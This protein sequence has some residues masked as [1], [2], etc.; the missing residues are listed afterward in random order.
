[1]AAAPGDSPRSYDLYLAEGPRR[2]FVKLTVHGITV[3]DRGLAW[4]SGGTACEAPFTD[5]AAIHLGAG[6]IGQSTLD[7]CRIEFT[8]GDG[9]AA[10]DWSASG[11]PDDGKLPIYRDF[12][13]DLHARLA[14]RSFGAI[15]F[16][17]GFPQWRYNIVLGAAIGLGLMWFAA[18][19]TT[20]FLAPGL[21]GLGILISGAFLLPPVIKLLRNTAPRSYTPDQLPIELLS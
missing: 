20:L 21:T 4:T 8:D 19:I 6:L 1:M 12:V 11:M 9:F 15:R 2:I 16:T 13:R 7:T 14:A 18:L 5:I 3:S 10:A 17:S